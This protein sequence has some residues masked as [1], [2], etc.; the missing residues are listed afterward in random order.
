MGML[1]K[2]EVQ[3]RYQWKARYFK[4]VDLE[5]NTLGFWQEIHNEQDI[6]VKVHHNVTSRSRRSAASEMAG[7]HKKVI[8]TKQ[9]YSTL[10]EAVG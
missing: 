9:G 6:L 7:R 10:D 8:W 2:Y 5:E 4:V 3:G 1:V